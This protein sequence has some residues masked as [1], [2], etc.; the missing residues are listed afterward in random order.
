MTNH[1]TCQKHLFSLPDDS[2]Y[3]N[4]ATMSPNLKAVEEAGVQGVLQKSQPHRITQETF[5][6]TT[7]AVRPLF[8]Q[9]VNCPD[10]ER[11]AFIPS[12]SYGMATVA[13]NLAYKPGLRAGQEILLI[14]EEF[15]SDVYAWEEV[16]ADKGLKI[17]TVAPPDGPEN[18]GHRWNERLLE[19]ISPETCMVVVP[20]VHWADGTRY[21]LAA[22]RV[23]TREVG[24]WLVVDGTQSVGAMPLD[25]Q[26]VQP[27]ALVCAGY[28]WLL[29][30]Y[31]TGLAYF[32]ETFD[33][34]RPL[35]Q[36]WINRAGSEE[37]SRLV[38]YRTEYR[39]KAA[40]YSVGEQ[41]NFILMPMLAAALRQLLDWQ[42]ERVQNYC[43]TLVGEPIQKL[44]NAGFWTEDEA[45]RGSHLFGVRPPA[46]TDIATVRQ[47]L[48]ERR[49]QVS[50]RGDAIRVSPHVY[51][52]AHQID[53]LVETLL[54]V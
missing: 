3:L 1:F 54:A 41:S 23:R 32:G 38:H 20:H 42:P 17:R 37:F 35:E 27:D 25:V 39:P 12:A 49:I 21:D 2:H 53:E 50:I 16:C 5:F 44:R 15:P 7:A 6:E 33:N 46:G 8:A 28:K 51:N 34:G 36:N 48:A 10:P 40:R 26:A 14:H 22:I 29:G 30:P 45:W 19:A 31:S 13:K 24:A 52:E 4:C 47:R 9:L 18:R 11:I 43:R